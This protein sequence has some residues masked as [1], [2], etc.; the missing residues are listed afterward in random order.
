MKL[1][2]VYNEDATVPFKN[3]DKEV[4]GCWDDNERKREDERGCKGATDEGKKLSP[5]SR[6]T[7]L[8]LNDLIMVKFEFSGIIPMESYQEYD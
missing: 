3:Q 4:I 7:L 2:S 6:R 8:R 1:R 5:N